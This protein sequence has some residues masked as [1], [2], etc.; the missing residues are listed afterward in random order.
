VDASLSPS[1]QLTSQP[2][3]REATSLLERP[4]QADQTSRLKEIG[5]RGGRGI[6]HRISKIVRQMQLVL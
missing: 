1:S 6:F 5:S 3:S 4:D 2:D